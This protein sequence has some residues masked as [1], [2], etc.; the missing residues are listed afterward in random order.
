MASLV[1]EADFS[2]ENFN[3]QAYCATVRPNSGQSGSLKSNSWV[4]ET[5]ISKS[6]NQSGA[7]VA[8]GLFSALRVCGL[9]L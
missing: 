4:T 7:F 8:A 5:V 2:V 6:S 1:S 9:R 3:S